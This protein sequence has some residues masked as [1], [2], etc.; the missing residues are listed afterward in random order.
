MFFS[1]VL[2]VLSMKIG[3]VRDKKDKSQISISKFQINSKF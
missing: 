3:V 2:T 1:F